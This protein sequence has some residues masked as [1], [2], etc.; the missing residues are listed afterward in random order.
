VGGTGVA[1]GVAV[2]VGDGVSVAVGVAVAVGVGVAV[3]WRAKTF[4]AESGPNWRS[5]MPPPT[6]QAAAI[7]VARMMRMARRIL[8]KGAISIDQRPLPAGG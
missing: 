7:V 1:V 6:R 8:G 3:A 2:A 5:A 4:H